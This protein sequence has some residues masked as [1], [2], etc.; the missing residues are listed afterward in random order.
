MNNRSYQFILLAFSLWLF[1]FIIIN[2]QNSCDDG[3]CGGDST[4]VA[5]T[6]DCLSP[7]GQSSVEMIEMAPRL[8][9]LDGKTIALVGGSFM[10]SVTHVELRKI[11]LENYPNATV[12]L[13]NEV[14][15][16][17]LFPGPRV[18]KP[19]VERFQ[20]RLQ[21]LGVDAVVSG[22]GG[23]GICTPKETGSCIAAEYIGIPSVMIAA[24]GFDTQARTT[25][26]NN[27]VPVLRVA[28]Y[29]GA[30]ASHTEAQLKENTRNVLW[31]Q[32]LE[33]LTTPITQEEIEANQQ[34]E[35]AD[36]QMAVFSGTIDEVNEFYSDMMWSDGMPIIPPTYERVA[37]FMNYTDYR[38]NRTIAVLSPSY[39]QSL[40][41]HVAVNG[42]MAGCKPEHMPILIALTKAMTSGDFRRTLGSTH[43]W[44]PYCWVNGPVARQLGLD[45]GQGQINEAANIAIGRFLNLAM[46]NLAGYYVKQDRMG[47]FGY[48]VSW[49]LAED[50]EACLRV[51]WNP[52]HVRQ[53]LGLNESAITAASTLMWGNNMP[54][55]TTDG[56]K[57]MQLLAWDITERCQL[58]LGSG[59]Q[60][61]HRAVLMTE[62]V[63]AHLKEKYGTVDAL[64]DQ[65]IATARRP[66]Y[67]RAFAHYYANPGS[68]I[69]P[70]RVSLQEY[71]DQLQTDENAEMTPTPEW[72]ACNDGQMLTIPTM[73][74]GETAFIITGDPS[75]NKIQTMPGGAWSTVA[76]ELPADWDDLMEEKGYQPLRSFYLEP[77]N[78]EG[79]DPLTT[80][81]EVAAQPVPRGNSKVRYY[82][83]NGHQSSRPFDGINI[84]VTTNSDSSV[85]SRK[86]LRSTP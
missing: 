35:P 6:Y 9:S 18:R 57:I 74:K 51:G 75:R 8:E 64:E 10:A 72:Y 86:I 37:E 21:E 56:E 63:A 70:D 34:L 14:G 17:G 79:V 33:A 26:Y 48:P 50:D 60:F 53:G 77:I 49:C 41:W 52:F 54:P 82:N 46:L 4:S 45:H 66:L 84:E 29:P 83:L 78:D 47:T 30:F 1:P 44:I 85:T 7:V 31:P 23:C 28:L 55:A 12:Y 62:E 22:N 20:Q 71:M 39:R 11:I 27:G 61:T 15:S 58:A 68:A 76:I 80:V 24:P 13:L 25:A 73:V 65:L 38:W 69:D 2:A 67:E 42:V 59:V 36:P 19:Q 81:D 40:V 32:I 3:S 5:G 43:A 16:A